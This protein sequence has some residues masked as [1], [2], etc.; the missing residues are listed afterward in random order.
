MPETEYP[1]AVSVYLTSDQLLLLDQERNRLRSEYGLIASHNDIIR[2]LI[3]LHRLRLQGAASD[4]V[5]ARLWM[6]EYLRHEDED[7]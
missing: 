5:G 6:Y 2:T 3:E 1:K 7:A 4:V